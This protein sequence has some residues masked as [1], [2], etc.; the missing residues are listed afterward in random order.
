MKRKL[1]ALLAERQQLV[2][3]ERT[4]R[5]AGW[6]RHLSEVRERLARVKDEISRLRGARKPA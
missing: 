1:T 6:F 2:E 4:Y 3:K 5:L